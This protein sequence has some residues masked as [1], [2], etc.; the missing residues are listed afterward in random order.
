MQDEILFS[1]TDQRPLNIM[2]VPITYT[3]GRGIRRIFPFDLVRTSLGKLALFAQFKTGVSENG[4]TGR[5]NGL[6]LYLV[7]QIKSAQADRFS[8]RFVN[9]YG[10]TVLSK[11]KEG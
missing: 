6:R 9:P 1:L 4:G 7:S 2:Y 10:N 11:I 8:R 5:K 3:G